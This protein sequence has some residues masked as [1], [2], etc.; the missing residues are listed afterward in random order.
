VRAAVVRPGGAL[1]VEERPTPQPGPGEVRVRLSACGICGTDLHFQRGGLWPPGRTPGHEMAGRVELVGEGVEGWRPGDPVAVEPLQA[2]GRCP[3]C[4]QGRGATCPELQVFGIHRDGGMAELVCVPAGRLFGVPADL[5]PPLAALAEP[6]A[7]AVHGLRRVE[8]E[9]GQQVLVLGAGSIG[10]LCVAA[11]RALGA[12]EVWLSARHP[13]QAVLGE[14]LGATRVLGE[15]EIPPECADL[16]VET[17]GGGADTLMQ[18]CHAVRRGGRI[19]V[20][21]VFMGRVEIDGLSLFLK[22]NT[23]SWSNCYVHP[24]EGADFETAIEL[25]SSRRDALAE[26]TRHVVPLAEIDRAFEV[27]SDKMSGAVK[28]TV[29]PEAQ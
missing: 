6:M 25:I 22:E 27:A 1:A 19:S 21:G 24:H 16:V 13:H 18:A 17:V 23:L 10:L 28:V 15:D 26:L 12:G 20:V 5:A 3:S 9:P 7:V 14:A 4:L 11:A 29:L 8:L 2:C